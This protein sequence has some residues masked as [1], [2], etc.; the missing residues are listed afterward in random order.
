MLGFAGL[1]RDLSVVEETLPQVQHKPVVKVKRGRL[2]PVS[3]V[4]PGGRPDDVEHRLTAGRGEPVADDRLDMIGA[5]IR[6]KCGRE[7]VIRVKR[8]FA[9]VDECVQRTGGI[10][11]LAF[12]LNRGRTIG[13]QPCACLWF[14]KYNDRRWIGDHDLFFAAYRLAICARRDR[15]CLKG[16]R[17]ALV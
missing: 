10:D 2:S 6:G 9:P 1:Q 7:A 14:G 3:Y 16:Q 11:D 15:A 12:D 4:V 8:D 13:T 17:S 5:K